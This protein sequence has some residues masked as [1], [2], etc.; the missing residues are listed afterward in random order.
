MSSRIL[1]VDVDMSE[2][3]META[4]EQVISAWKGAW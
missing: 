3:C 4:F 1:M 2:G